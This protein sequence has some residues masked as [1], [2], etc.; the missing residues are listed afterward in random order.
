LLSYKGGNFVRTRFDTELDRRDY[1]IADITANRIMVA[2]AHTRTL[3]NL[4]ISDVVQSSYENIVSFSLSLERVVA[5]FPNITWT[6]SLI[7]YFFFF[8]FIFEIYHH[9][10]QLRFIFHCIILYKM[11]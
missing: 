6:E 2:V 3:S 9:T 7:W 11:K 8:F 1:H 5:Y 10:H 4:Y